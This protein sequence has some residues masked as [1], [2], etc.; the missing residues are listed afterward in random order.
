[1]KV[2]VKF[3]VFKPFYCKKFIFHKTFKKLS[4][5]RKYAVLLEYCK[6]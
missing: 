6:I 1:M 5:T 4:P 3:T 2:N